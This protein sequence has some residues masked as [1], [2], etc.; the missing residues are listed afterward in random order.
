MFA[1]ANT[2]RLPGSRLPVP[3][4]FNSEN[5]KQG[6]KLVPKIIEKERPKL[7]NSRL[8]NPAMSEPPNNHEEYTGH[9]N[10]SVWKRARRVPVKTKSKA[11]TPKRALVTPLS[12]SKSMARQLGQ[13]LLNGIAP[14]RLFDTLKEPDQEIMDDEQAYQQLLE[15]E[16]KLK[17]ELLE[18]DI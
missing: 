12:A 15:E 14:K 1:R 17:Q 6:P 9:R 5:Q 4:H 8:M 18:F 13:V 3:S 7:V 16:A 10:K 11:I 2:H